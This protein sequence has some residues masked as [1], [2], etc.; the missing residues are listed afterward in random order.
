VNCFVIKKALIKKWVEGTHNNLVVKSLT[1]N[2][3]EIQFLKKEIIII[4]SSLFR[5]FAILK[6]GGRV[7]WIPTPNLL[8]SFLSVQHSIKVIN[9]VAQFF[10][11]NTA[12]ED[13]NFTWFDCKITIWCYDNTQKRWGEKGIVAPHVPP[14]MTSKYL[15]IKIQ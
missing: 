9:T 10:K 1:W 5:K 13:N 14:Q 3:L 8:R 12:N 15:V 2:L 11:R 4:E 6:R 7:I